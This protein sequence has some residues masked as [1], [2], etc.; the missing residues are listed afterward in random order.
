MEESSAVFIPKGEEAPLAEDLRA[1]V[2]NDAGDPAV[3]D[4]EDDG[5]WHGGAEEGQHRQEKDEVK[6][7]EGKAPVGA[8]VDIPD[9]GLDEEQKLLVDHIMDEQE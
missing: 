1:P 7:K 3:T 8:K 2:G 5:G 6:I 4:G 9:M